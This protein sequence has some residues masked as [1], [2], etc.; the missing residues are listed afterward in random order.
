METQKRA[1]VQGLIDMGFLIPNLNVMYVRASFDANVLLKTPKAIRNIVML[2][3][4]WKQSQ[5]HVL[6]L[7]PLAV[8]LKSTFYYA[9]Y[10]TKTN[11]SSWVLM[12]QFSTSIT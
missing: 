8:G 4:Q 1:H 9:T 12:M 6:E 3:L 11:Y 2:T 5:T 7:V 10:E